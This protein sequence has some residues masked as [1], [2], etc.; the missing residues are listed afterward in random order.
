MIIFVFRRIG[1]WFLYSV[2]RGDFV[3]DFGLTLVYY[4]I[5]GG[6][7]GLFSDSLGV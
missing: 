2:V 5:V 7:L 4:S 3:F 6:G 1:R